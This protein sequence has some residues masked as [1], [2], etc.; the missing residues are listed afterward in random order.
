MTSDN[1]PGLVRGADGPQRATLL[2]LFFDLVYVAALA[3]SSMDLSRDLSWTGA[4]KAVL[5]LMGIWWVWS[6]TATTTDFYD[7]DRRPIQA[8]LGGVMLATVLMAASLPRAFGQAGLVFAAAYSASHLGRGVV[9]V[10]AQHSGPTRK[11]AARFMFWFGVSSVPWILGGFAHNGARAVLW[12]FA[13]AID[14]VL[15]GLRYPTPGLGRVPVEQYE[16]T[17]EHLGE[18]YQQFMILALG[19]MI[20][21]AVLRYSRLTFTGERT[22]AILVAFATTVLLWQIYVRHAGALLQTTVTRN[23]TR[24][25]RWAPFTH[26]IMVLGIATTA[27]GFD[28]VIL[29]PGGSTP[30]GWVSAIFGGPALFLLGRTTFEFEAFGRASRTRVL[31]FVVILA[32]APPTVLVPPLYAAAILAAILLATAISDLVRGRGTADRV[33]QALLRRRP[34]DASG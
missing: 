16:L 15:N 8:I 30:P 1:A 10:A 26:L 14:L 34:S 25:S 23:P 12:A 32:A 27:A 5:P 7:P 9:L 2:E 29:R 13:L 22:A 17:N 4:V 31:W 24:S 33:E 20:L 28:V 21:V 3:L 19:D 18:R 11:R 6:I